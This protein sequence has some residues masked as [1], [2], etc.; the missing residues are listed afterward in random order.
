MFYNVENLFDTENDP[1]TNDDEFT[2]MGDRHWNTKK[3]NK[4]ISNISKVIAAAGG[5]EKPAII[6]LCEIE[7]HFVLEQ[8]CNHPLLRKYDYHII[9]KE[10]PDHR[11]IDVA[12]LYRKNLFSPENY[13]TIPIINEQDTMATREI[14][15]VTGK[16][17]N[18][19]TMHFF[20]NHWPSRYNGILETEPKR[21]LAAK[22]LKQAID[23]L[24]SQTPNVRIICMGDFNDQPENKSIYE[25][26]G[27]CPQQKKEKDRKLTNLTFLTTPKIKGTIKYKQE[28]TFFDQFIVTPNLLPRVHASIFSPDFLLEPDKKY[29]GKKPFRTYIGFKYNN[30][31]S[32]HLPIILKLAH[33]KTGRN[34]T[35]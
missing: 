14:L 12:M 6:G 13:S 24:Q 10:S 33:I 16:F 17:Q 3:M 32:D 11:G 28:W 35:D 29:T 34:K 1:A 15:Y 23:K 21:I 18:G 8:L 20:V 30:G 25:I 27:A 31:F 26:L 7:N 19:E 2:P 9:H 22:R 5:W 4:K